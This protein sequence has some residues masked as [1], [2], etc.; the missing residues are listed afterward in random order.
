MN[1]WTS[2]GP[3]FTMMSFP[4]IHRI[5]SFDPHIGETFTGFLRGN[6]GPGIFGKLAVSVERHEHV[7]RD[8]S[9]QVRSRSSFLSSDKANYLSH[10][11]TASFCLSISYSEDVGPRYLKQCERVAAWIIEP[12]T[13]SFRNFEPFSLRFPALLSKLL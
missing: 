12:V 7:H 1:S 11:P 8:L 6:V 3:A 2:E 10:S 4:G 13:W 9:R 5:M